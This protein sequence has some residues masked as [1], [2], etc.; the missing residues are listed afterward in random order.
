MTPP[1]AP[2]PA[3]AKVCF[4]CSRPTCISF[5]GWRLMHGRNMVEMWLD[6]GRLANVT[7]PPP[8][9][10]A[11]ACIR[12]SAGWLEY[13]QCTG[14]AAQSVLLLLEADA[15]FKY[16][17]AWLVSSLA[18][19]EPCINWPRLNTS[20]LAMNTSLLCCRLTRGSSTARTWLVFSRTWLVSSHMAGG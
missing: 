11:F 19:F 16:A 6:C 17:R 1:P 10:R 2:R 18:I 20:H 3:R 15:W 14:A 12:C 9:A 5:C 13:G 4:G 8:R 7:P